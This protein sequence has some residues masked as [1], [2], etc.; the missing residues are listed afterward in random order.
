MV[1]ISYTSALAKRYHL[2][3]ES[4]GCQLHPKYIMIDGISNLGDCRA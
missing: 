1:F 2:I 4:Y 3:G